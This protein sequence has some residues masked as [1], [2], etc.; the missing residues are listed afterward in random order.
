MKQVIAS[1]TELKKNPSALL[2]KDEGATVAILN[3]NKPA[4][5]LV[6]AETYEWMVEAID[7]YELI[8]TIESRCDELS[9]AIEVSLDDL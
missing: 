2:K 5:Y 9:E 8:K 3:H 6:P 4:A 1:L 7:D